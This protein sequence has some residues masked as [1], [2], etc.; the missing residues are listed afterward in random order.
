M[1]G[2]I[3][4]G[5]LARRPRRRGPFGL[6]ERVPAAQYRRGGAGGIPEGV[7]KRWP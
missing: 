6:A 5:R 7:A 3:G 2:G 1:E 4:R